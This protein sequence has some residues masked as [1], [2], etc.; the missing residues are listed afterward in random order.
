M[1]VSHLNLK[2]QM[3]NYSVLSVQEKCILQVFRLPTITLFTV[4]TYINSILHMQNKIKLVLIQLQIIM[5]F[6]NKRSLE[7]S[8]LY[9]LLEF[10]FCC[11]TINYAGIAIKGLEFVWVIKQKC[12]FS[13]FDVSPRCANFSCYWPLLT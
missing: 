4:R 2:L 7:Y 3:W 10:Y 13:A 12:R 9:T 1:C 6:I 8:K 5:R 11:G